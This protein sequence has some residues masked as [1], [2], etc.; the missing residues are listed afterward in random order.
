M[1]QAPVHVHD[2]VVL[3]EAVKLGGDQREPTPEGDGRRIGH[4]QG[5]KQPVSKLESS[6][7]WY[8]TPVEAG[9][10]RASAATRAPAGAAAMIQRLIILPS[11]SGLRGDKKRAAETLGISLKTLY[12]RLSLYQAGNP[13][14][15]ADMTDPE[16]SHDPVVGP[17]I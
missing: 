16:S 15:A 8:E 11:R 14:N 1:R 5:G 17:G 2:V 3:V 13:A 4:R 6:S 9:S 10:A 12:S 7:S